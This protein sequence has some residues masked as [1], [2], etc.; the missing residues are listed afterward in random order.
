ML[1]YHSYIQSFQVSFDKDTGDI[2]FFL[3][4]E[5]SPKK[6][7]ALIGLKREP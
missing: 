7:R 2:V 4:L 5:N 1:E 3:F 6:I